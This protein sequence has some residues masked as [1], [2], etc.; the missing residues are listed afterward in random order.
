MLSRIGFYRLNGLLSVV[1]AAHLAGCGKVSTENSEELASEQASS[2]GSGTTT[3]PAATPPAPG[4]SITIG[5]STFNLLELDSNGNPAPIT[6]A[7]SDAKTFTALIGDVNFS[8]AVNTTDIGL[9]NNAAKFGKDE[10]ATWC[11]GDTNG[12]KRLTADDLPA[13]QENFNKGPQG[14]ARVKALYGDANMDGKVNS[15]D[16]MLINN[17]QKFGKDEKATWCE[18]DFNQDRRVTQA[19]IDAVTENWLKAIS[20]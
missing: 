6:E 17:A 3:D 20:K 18:G 15:I 16:I 8:G 9:I 1:L 14:T 2:G 7:P 11:D 4:E 12:D 5:S 13:L 19:D 10:Y